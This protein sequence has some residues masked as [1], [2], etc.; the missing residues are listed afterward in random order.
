MSKNAMRFEEDAF[1]LA[2]HKRA[3]DAI[4]REKARQKRV[5]R[6]VKIGKVILAIATV[7][8]FFILFIVAANMGLMNFR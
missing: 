1:D 3:A 4:I 8:V 5:R 7:A 2:E 6:H